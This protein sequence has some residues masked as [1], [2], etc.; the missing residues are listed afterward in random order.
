MEKFIFTFKNEDGVTGTFGTEAYPFIVSDVTGL[1]ESKAN[2]TMS[3]NVMTDGS[4]YQ[5]SVMEKRNIVFTLRDYPNCDHAALRTKLST[6]FK[7]KAPGLLTITR[8]P[9]TRQIIYYPESIQVDRKR[10]SHKYT[11]SLLCPSPLYT[12]P[13]VREMTLGGSSGGFYFAHFFKPEGHPL[14]TRSNARTMVVESI[15]AAESLGLTITITAENTIKN[16]YIRLVE[17]GETFQLGSGMH[18]L[19]LMPGDVVTITTHSGNKRAIL[20]RDGETADLSPYIT[21]DSEFLQLSRGRNTFTAGCAGTGGLG[22]MNVVI[23]YQML[24]EGF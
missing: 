12:D 24:Y 23:R 17:T 1:L 18:V 19:S 2:V 11:V 9:D 16:P 15:S 8:G 13:K 10:R 3:E 7:Y 5:G 14:A 20:T 22:D 21:E 4:T 6:L